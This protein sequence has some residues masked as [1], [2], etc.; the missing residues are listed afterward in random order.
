M[1]KAN[2]QKTN[3]PFPATEQA[4]TY[5]QSDTGIHPDTKAHLEFR[6]TGGKPLRF[7][8]A[9]TATQ[10]TFTHAPAPHTAIPWLTQITKE[11]QR[12]KRHIIPLPVSETHLGQ[13]FFT[14]LLT[15]L[16]SPPS[17]GVARVCCVHWHRHSTSSKKT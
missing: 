1:S 11:K 17:H 9:Y 3:S 4:Q 15:I 2:P 16:I 5:N 14:P 13:H 12:D 6:Q 7:C 8:F 10:D